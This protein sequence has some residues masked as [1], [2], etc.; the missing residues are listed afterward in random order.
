MAK[1]ISFASN[2]PKMGGGQK[3]KGYAEGGVVEAP[4]V[5]TRDAS[6]KGLVYSKY[7][8]TMEA[9]AKAPTVG[10]GQAP[11]VADMP[12]FAKPGDVQYYGTE[13]KD[14]ATKINQQRWDAY[15]RR[16]S[17]AAISTGNVMPGA[18]K[19][20][21]VYEN[22]LQFTAK[23]PGATGGPVADTKQAQMKLAADNLVNKLQSL[24]PQSKLLAS[25]S[26]FIEYAKKRKKESM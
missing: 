16:V 4:K 23:A 24:A 3:V 6:G 12:T 18:E 22:K 26:N 2:N 7:D 20:S 9:E 14:E 25:A 11:K 13:F 8:T 1:V 21:T 15:N 19:P 5:D 17:N 10:Y